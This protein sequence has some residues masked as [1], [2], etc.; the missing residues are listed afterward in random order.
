MI[1]DEQFRAIASLAVT[2]LEGLGIVVVLAG[3]VVRTVAVEPTLEYVGVLALIV[4]VRT[5]SSFVL[6]SGDHG[7]LAVAASPR[8]CGRAGARPRVEP[9]VVDDVARGRLASEP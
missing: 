4:L 7:S 3:D 5:G 1:E 8:S 2:V 9:A 6:E